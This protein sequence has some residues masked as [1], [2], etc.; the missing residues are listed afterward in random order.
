MSNSLRTY[1]AVL[2]LLLF[3]GFNSCKKEDP[4]HPVWMTYSA[5]ET[6]LVDQREFN[7]CADVSGNI[8]ALQST[9]SADIFKLVYHKKG[10]DGWQT[11]ELSFVR[12]DP[13]Y[14]TDEN[15][16]KATTDGSVWLLGKEEMLRLKDGEVSQRYSLNSLIEQGSAVAV[17]RFATFGTE[18]WL[19]HWSNGLFQL[20]TETGEPLSF[21]DPGYSGTDILLSIDSEGNRWIVKQNYPHNVIA[22]AS[23]GS[24]KTVNDP[25]SLIGCP[26]CPS[27]GYGVPAYDDFRGMVS[28]AVG[29]TYLYSIDYQLLRISNGTVQSMALSIGPNYDAMTVDHDDRLWFYKT[30]LTSYFSGDSRIY[31]YN[32]GSSPTVV[33]LTDTFE[34]NV[35]PYDLTFDHNNNTWI[36]TNKGI[37]VYNENGVEF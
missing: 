23:D 18:V 27:T 8:Y 32:G 12:Q 6:G 9:D 25:D 21:H 14:V 35:W 10:S 3:F 15:H 30:G 37:A 17:S 7:I 16:M 1:L 11:T 20:N 2:L 26:A 4:L 5:E 22:L 36:S 13:W 24:W 33:D 29:N 19:L 31:R 28:D 34:G